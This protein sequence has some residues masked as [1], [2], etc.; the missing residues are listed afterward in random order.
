MGVDSS[1]AMLAAAREVLPDL[2]FVEGDLAAWTAPEPAAVLYSNAALQWLDGHDRLF[3][4]L[5]GQLKPGGVLAVQMP[6]NHGEPSHQAMLAAAG[7]GPWR[8]RLA[9][10]LRPSPVAP[11]ETYHRLL[12]PLAERLDIWETVYQH[13]LSGEN[14][15]AAGRSAKATTRCE[16][17]GG[18]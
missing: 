13:E 11:P 2:A 12:R 4:R 7:A 8:E 5:L 18:P 6:R 3:P 17:S 9:P 16:V 14:P 10:L 15:V 1:P